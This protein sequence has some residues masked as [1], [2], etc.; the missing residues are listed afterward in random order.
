[1]GVAT[2]VPATLAK[3]EHRPVLR[4]VDDENLDE[5][6]D[7]RHPQPHD[8]LRRPVH[9]GPADHVLGRLRVPNH[10]VRREGDHY[11]LERNMEEH[12]THGHDEQDRQHYP[13]SYRQERKQ[14]LLPLKVY[15]REW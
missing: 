7:W 14:E 1:M 6:L 12:A 9:M 10:Q 8:E 13:L 11:V 3:L 15:D 2:G 5:D 4:R